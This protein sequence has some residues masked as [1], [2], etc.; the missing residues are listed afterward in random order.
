MSSPAI[1]TAVTGKKIIL[2][3]VRD[4]IAPRSL[5]V[6]NINTDLNFETFVFLSVVPIAQIP[7]SQLRPLDVKV[8]L[9]V[10]KSS[11]IYLG[12]VFSWQIFFHFFM[13]K[14]S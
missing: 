7:A 12:L 2:E 5:S 10:I 8:I 13:A 9:F 6:E 3:M 11:H 14:F 1:G 4:P